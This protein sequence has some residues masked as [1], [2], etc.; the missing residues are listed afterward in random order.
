[1]QVYKEGGH[2]LFETD[3]ECSA[4]VSKMLAHLEKAGMDAVREYSQKFDDWC[5]ADFELSPE[6]VEGAIAAWTNA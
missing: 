5:P 2:R 4:I 6:Q 1:M 3:P